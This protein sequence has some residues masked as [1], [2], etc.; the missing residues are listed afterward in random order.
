M[1]LSSSEVEVVYLRKRVFHKALLPAPL[2]PGNRKTSFRMGQ[3]SIGIRGEPFDV[4]SIG[5]IPRDES[6]VYMRGLVDD[7]LCC[8]SVKLPPFQ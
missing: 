8:F 2:E 4:I 7:D 1:P 5:V 6:E 3:V